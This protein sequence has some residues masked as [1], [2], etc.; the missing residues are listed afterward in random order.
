MQGLP[1]RG[2]G[3]AVA[4]RPAETFPRQVGSEAE[5]PGPGFGLWPQPVSLQQ[6]AFGLWFS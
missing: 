3:W 1:R 6:P 4:A 2:R 5:T